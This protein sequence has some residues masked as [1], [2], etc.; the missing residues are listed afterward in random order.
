[1]TRKNFKAIADIM[2]KYKLTSDEITI[3]KL[4]AELATYFKTDNPTFDRSKFMRACG[5]YDE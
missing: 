5:F 3:N 2:R 1:M 4:A